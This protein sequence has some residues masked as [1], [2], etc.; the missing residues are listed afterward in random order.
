[1]KIVN[2]KVAQRAPEG[3][4]DR[5]EYNRQF[6]PKLSRTTL[7]TAHTIYIGTKRIV[8]QHSLMFC[9]GLSSIAGYWFI[10]LGFTHISIL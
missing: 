8:I 6:L 1:M 5:D 10:D 4:W 3:R 2:G 7:F 9:L